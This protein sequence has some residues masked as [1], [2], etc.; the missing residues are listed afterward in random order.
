MAARQDSESLLMALYACMYFAALR[1]AEAV[2]LRQ[3]D[4]HLPETGWGRLTLETSR[5]EVNR[6]WTDTAS[7]HEERGLK[8][9]PA[10]ESRRVPIPPELVGILRAHVGAFGVAAHGRIFSSERGRVI[11][12]T[13]ISDVWAEA[14]TLA[15]T[16]SRSPPRWQSARTTCATRPCLSGSTREYRRPRSPS[17][18]VIV[19]RCCSGCMPNAWTTARTSPTPG[20]KPRSN[21][22]DDNGTAGRPVI[23]HISPAHRLTAPFP[24]PCL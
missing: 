14:R 11:A 21:W 6:R 23:P 18:P 24:R 5:P 1:P 2:A 7:A 15:L 16:P 10:Q 4:C 9:R 17:A 3:Q 13:A 22:A 8:H 20:S 12:S 19:S